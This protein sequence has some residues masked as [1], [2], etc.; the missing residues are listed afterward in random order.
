MA[1]ERVLVVGSGAAGLAAAWRLACLGFSVS[2]LESAERPGGRIGSEG[3]EGFVFDRGPWLLSTAD[4]CAASLLRELELEHTWMPLYAAGIFQAT[5]D[6]LVEIDPCTPRGIRRIPGVGWFDGLRV[7][8]FPRLARRFRPQIDPEHPE[9]ASDLDYRSLADFAT[10]YFGRS[11]L[12]HWIAP[13]LSGTWPSEAANA[14]RVSFLLHAVSQSEVSPVIL[15]SGM[16]VLV[17][18]ITERVDTRLA[19]EGLHVETLPSGDLSLRLAHSGIEEQQVADAVVLAT[20]PAQGLRLAESELA[21]IERRFLAG[22]ADQMSITLAL[23]MTSEAFH[24]PHRIQVPRSLQIPIESIWVEPGHLTG[25]AP[26]GHCLVR[27]V[28]RDIWARVHA[29]ATDEVVAKELRAHLIRLDSRF[30]APVRICKVLR[31]D[32]SFP[33]FDV[34]RYR[35]LAQFQKVQTDRRVQGRHLYFAGDYLQ[36]PGVESALVSGLRAAQDVAADF[37]VTGVVR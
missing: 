12:E 17:R 9:K 14:S 21:W 6:G 16:G 28:T 36:G 25:R 35:A 13:W 29:G 15:R 32:R 3:E 4:H 8:R 37:G 23:G 10:L 7:Y 5:W 24:K 33:R 1:G 2:I 31:T 11:A 19:V 27:V 26:E 18:A 20:S 30:E 34:G 22:A